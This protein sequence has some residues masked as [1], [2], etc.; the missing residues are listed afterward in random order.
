MTV[1]KSSAAEKKAP[2]NTAGCSS[3][4]GGALTPGMRELTIQGGSLQNFQNVI[5]LL[6]LGKETSSEPLTYE[7]YACGYFNRGVYKNGVCSYH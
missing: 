5:F 7:R 4:A 6:S 1:W 3:N 2:I